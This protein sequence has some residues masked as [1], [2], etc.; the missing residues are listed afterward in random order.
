MDF[1]SISIGQ[2]GKGTPIAGFMGGVSPADTSQK[3]A[4][5]IGGTHGD[6]HEG[7]T[8]AE[9]LLSSLQK[10]H[11]NESGPLPFSFKLVIVPVLNPDGY[12]LDQRH[13]ANGVDLNRNLPT[14][15]WSA[16]VSDPRYHPGATPA[17][18][19]ETQALLQALE[20]FSPDFILSL[21]SW[22]KP[23]VLNINGPCRAFA[24]TVH[25][26]TGFEIKED[27]GYPTPGSLGT[28]WGLE[29]ERPTLTYEIQRVSKRTPQT[30]ATILQTHLS[31]VWIC[32]EHVSNHFKEII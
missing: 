1:S 32:L 28:Y 14:K 11:F 21:H 3:C 30:T 12:F 27:I 5:V 6:E 24:E 31:A 16:K 23:P 2:T 9:G 29:R 8:L 10:S 22:K 20:R 18:E 15:D 26:K 17:S 25:N 7:V 4:M 13:N 19:P